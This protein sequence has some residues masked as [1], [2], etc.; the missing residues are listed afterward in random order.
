MRQIRVPLL[1]A[2][3]GFRYFCP[4]CGVELSVSNYE[5]PG[6]DYFCPYCGTEQRASR[7]PDPR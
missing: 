6:R 2:E 5:T 7:V 1:P 4:I 3:E